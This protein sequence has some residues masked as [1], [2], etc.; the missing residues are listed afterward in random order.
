MKVSTEVIKHHDQNQPNEE[1]VYLILGY[2][3]IALGEVR[4]R[5]QA[6]KELGGR[7]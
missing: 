3:L 2:Q 5:T 7:E 1:R 6:G 4:T